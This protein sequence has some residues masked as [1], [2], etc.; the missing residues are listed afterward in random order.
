MKELEVTLLLLL[1][2]RDCGWFVT[3]HFNNELRK[4]IR[5]IFLKRKC[6]LKGWEMEL[7][8]AI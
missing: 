1:A 8:M 4:L 2:L 7:I 5:F 3:L 6:I